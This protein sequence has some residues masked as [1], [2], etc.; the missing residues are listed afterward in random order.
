MAVL[1]ATGRMPAEVA[2]RRHVENS[3]GPDTVRDHPDVVRRL[4]TLQRAGP[5]AAGFQAQLNAGARFSSTRQSTITAPTLVLH[6]TADRVVDPRNARLLAE[7]IPGARLELLPGRGHLF[8]WEDP[9]A[10][11]ATVTA[12]ALEGPP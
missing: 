3:L 4:M 9:A 10:F 8:F 5:G 2:L 1:S 6:G 12:F 7:R 11:V